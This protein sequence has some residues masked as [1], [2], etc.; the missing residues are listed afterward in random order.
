MKFKLCFTKINYQRL[1]IS[2]L[3]NVQKYFTIYISIGLHMKN[4]NNYNLGKN[5]S[6]TI[7]S[8]GY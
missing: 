3:K 2:K 4:G 5:Y 6:N 1:L 8:N 7:L